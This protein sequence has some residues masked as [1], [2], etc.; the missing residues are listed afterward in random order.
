VAPS[1]AH[2]PIAGARALV[3]EDEFLIAIDVQRILETAGAREVV[4]AARVAD[5]MA[6][7]DGPEPFDIAVLDILLGEESGEPVA[8][9]LV[10]RGIPFV[11]STGIGPSGV[12]TEGAGAMPIVPKPYTS[13]TLLAGLAK[14]SAMLRK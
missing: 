5:A 2:D 10:E 9:R 12:N 1:P 14:A 13:A 8:K 3:V 6:A 7:L 4:L 11:Y